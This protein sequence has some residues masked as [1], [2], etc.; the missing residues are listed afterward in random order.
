MTATRSA[1]GIG[2]QYAA[3]GGGL[4]SALMVIGIVL[5]NA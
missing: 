4:L 3:M 5:M 2:R 1:N